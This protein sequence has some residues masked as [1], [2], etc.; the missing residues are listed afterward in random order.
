MNTPGYLLRDTEPVSVQDY[1]NDGFSYKKP[2]EYG[3]AGDETDFFHTQPV[4]A[5]D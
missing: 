4:G 1:Y 5:D 2:Q 3:N